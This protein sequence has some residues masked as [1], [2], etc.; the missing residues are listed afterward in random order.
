MVADPIYMHVRWNI[1]V[2]D[3]VIMELHVHHKY[4]LLELKIGI[5]HESNTRCYYVIHSEYLLDFHWQ[6]PIVIGLAE[7]ANHVFV[8]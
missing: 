7:V 1:C 3:I 5:Y 8:I 6:V 4:D 2:Y